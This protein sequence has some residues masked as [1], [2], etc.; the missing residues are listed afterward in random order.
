MPYFGLHVPTHVNGVSDGILN[1]QDTYEDK[2]EWDSKARNLADRFI[3]NFNKFTDTE[4]GKALVA[5]GP[6]ID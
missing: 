1:P 5:A 3:T 6:A 2:A 4:E